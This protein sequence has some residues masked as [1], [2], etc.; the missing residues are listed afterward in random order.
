M[1]VLGVRA[2]CCQKGISIMYTGKYDTSKNY[3]LFDK[4]QRIAPQWKILGT[5]QKQPRF[6]VSY[7]G[8]IV[9]RMC[10]WTSRGILIETACVFC[11]ANNPARYLSTY[12]FQMFSLVLRENQFYNGQNS[13]GYMLECWTLRQP[14]Q[15]F[16]NK[17]KGNSRSCKWRRTLLVCIVYELWRERNLIKF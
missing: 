5:W 1:F 11:S 8:Q 4:T 9:Y 10:T 2:V 17:S 7:E 15:W 14:I 16:T 12:V 13:T 6:L 3:I